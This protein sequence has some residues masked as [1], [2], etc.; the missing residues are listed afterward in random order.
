LPAAS[1]RSA[2]RPFRTL[3]SSGPFRSPLSYVVIAPIAERPTWT[4][5]PSRNRGVQDTAR[6][7]CITTRRF[8]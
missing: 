2:P 6:V 4:G 8:A 5:L 3:L 7:G 1:R